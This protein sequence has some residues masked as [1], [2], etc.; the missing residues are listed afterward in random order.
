[1]LKR[2]LCVS[3]LLLASCSIN[4]AK[5]DLRVT[6]P[7][8]AVG[9]GAMATHPKLKGRIP[10]ASSVFQ[11]YVVRLAFSPDGRYLAVGDAGSPTVVIWDV[12]NNKEQSRFKVAHLA[13]N[14]RGGSRHLHWYPKE[15]LVWSPDGRFVT[16][17][18]GQAEAHGNDPDLPIEFFNPMTGNVEYKLDAYSIRSGQFNR[19]GSKFL[20]ISNEGRFAIYNTLSWEK[21][22]PG[23]RDLWYDTGMP[24]TEAYSWTSD[25]RVLIVGGWSG[26]LTNR[27]RKARALPPFTPG[28]IP[29]KF[30]KIIQKIDPSEKHPVE[31]SVLAEPV[32]TNNPQ[33]PYDPPFI[34]ATM[35]LNFSSHR[36]AIACDAIRIIK[37]SSLQTTF[38]YPIPRELGLKPTYGM[39]FGANGRYL[40]ILAH[41][42]T[43]KEVNSKIIDTET[44]NVVGSFPSA[45]SW[46]LAISPDG[47]TMAVGHRNH[48][49]LYD[50][51]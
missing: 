13:D 4:Q 41:D 35:T 12:K 14:R 15:K 32:P 23:G 50:L 17:G 51:Y 6:A 1:M 29:P 16:T 48:I 37:E 49:E 11:F 31:I 8:H 26:P 22:F 30:S 34:C 20:T 33:F 28:N 18:I 46:G 7:E 9:N 42:P 27:Q 40:Y 39:E 10:I 44:G 5:V 43:D 24:T 36:A 21:Q 38:I 19:D 2:L 25:D 47:K 3:T 45:D